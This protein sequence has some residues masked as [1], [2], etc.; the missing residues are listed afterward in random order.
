MRKEWMVYGGMWG[1][2]LLALAG[3]VY[4]QGRDAGPSEGHEGGAT[5][6]RASDGPASGLAPREP[7][8]AQ[9]EPNESLPRQYRMD[10]RHTGRTS[11]RG[12]VTSQRFWDYETGGDVVSQ[13]AAAADGTVYVG[14]HD[15]HVYAL[16]PTGGVRWQRDL[17]DDVYASPALVGDRVFVGS[18]A[19]FFFILDAATGEVLV[20]LRTDGDVDTGIAVDDDGTAY[21]G[22]GAELWSVTSDGTVRFRFQTNDKIFSAPAID[23]DGTV[24]VGSQDDHVYAVTREGELRWAFAAQNDVDSGPVVGDDGTIYFG[25]DDRRVYAVDR[26]GHER[27]R[28][29]VGGYVRTPVSLGRDGNVLVPVYGPEARVV[30]LDAATGREQWT[31]SVGRTTSNEVGVGSSPLVDVDGNIYFGASDH[32]VYAIDRTGRMR[33]IHGTEGAIDADPALVADGVLVV[34]SDDRGVHAVRAV[35]EPDAGATL[36]ADDAGTAPRANGEANG[37][38]NGGTEDDTRP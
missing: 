20:H 16:T 34:G 8:A 22:A 31:F 9:R 17:G 5:R 28:A 36:E 11:L 15:H 35:A 33:W 38:A 12:P 19:N 25:S 29:E 18:D 3:I 37:A 21:F 26:N 14:S 7:T 6:R 27:W 13:V 2:A 24:Y 10:R 1:A 23:D 30:S 4:V 32:Y